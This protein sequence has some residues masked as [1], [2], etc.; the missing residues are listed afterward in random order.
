MKVATFLG[1][2]HFGDPILLF[3]SGKYTDTK[4]HASVSV[5]LFRFCFTEHNFP[6]LL[7]HKYCSRLLVCYIISLHS[8]ITS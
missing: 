1:E 6:S 4:L 8:S 2:C 5:I 7:C 3:L